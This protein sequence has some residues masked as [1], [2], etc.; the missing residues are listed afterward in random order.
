MLCQT[1]ECLTEMPSDLKELI[2]YCTRITSAL[3]R[4]H[5]IGRENEA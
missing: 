2:V 1:S 5:S 4:K 3:K